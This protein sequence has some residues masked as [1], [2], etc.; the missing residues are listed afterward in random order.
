M[1]NSKERSVGI[2]GKCVSKKIKNKKKACQ[3]RKLAGKPGLYPKKKKASKLGLEVK[4]PSNLLLKKKF[5]F[6]FKRT[7]E[8]HNISVRN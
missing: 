3:R 4:N 1:C 2:V 7:K 8:M 6:Y 5:L